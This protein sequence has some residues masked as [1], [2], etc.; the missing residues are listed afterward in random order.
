[1]LAQMRSHFD[2]ALVT[3]WERL[4]GGYGLPDPDDEHVVAAAVVGG[5]DVIVTDNL[6]DFPAGLLPSHIDVQDAKVFAAGAVSVD[7]ECAARALAQIARRHKNPPESSVALLDALVTVYGM[8][9][10]EELLRPLLSD[11]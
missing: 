7:P 6:P 2:D 10:I 5:A 9:E 4:E 8:F 1:M 3:G 11:E